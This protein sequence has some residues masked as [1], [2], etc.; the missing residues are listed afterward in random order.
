M[1]I[2]TPHFAFLERHDLT[3]IIIDEAGSAHY[4]VKTRPYL[5][6]RDALK[7]YAQ[8]TKR[9]LVY[10]DILLRTEE[11]ALRREDVYATFDEPTKRISFDSAFTIAEHPAYSA[12]EKFSVI[13]QELR[14]GIDR[15]LQGKGHVFLFAARR[16]FAPLI[17]CFDCGH[18]FRCPDSGAPYSLFESGRGDQKERWFVSPTSGRRVRAADICPVCGSWRLKEQ[19]IGIQQIAQFVRAHVKS[20]PVI[21]FDHTTATTA[22]KARK[23][24]EQFYDAKT[25]AVLIGTAMA[26]PYLT[27]PV[28]LTAV[29]SY[30]AARAIP[31]WRAEETLLRMLLLLREATAHECIIQTRS[32]VDPLLKYAARGLT[33]AF[34]TE[35][36]EM[37]QALKYPPFAHFIL[38]SWIGTGNALRDIEAQVLAVLG[39]TSIHCYNN[40]VPTTKGT[41]R[42]GLIR[43]PRSAWPDKTLADK[44][45]QLPPS[46]RIEV[47]PE[48]II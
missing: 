23:L 18:I 35:E 47:A 9:A 4:K 39:D 48:K 34:Y 20:V 3:T 38:L 24:A 37:R 19:G 16:G 28:E 12:H 44:L 14:D 31:T 8:V 17:Y 33:D 1:I 29:T 36:I 41:I 25:G 2:T 10:G 15:T 40:P 32:E 45:R 7:T 30:E 11:E 22:E 5:D 46:V 21:I 27:Q 26:L 43:L 6:M 42:H 13:T